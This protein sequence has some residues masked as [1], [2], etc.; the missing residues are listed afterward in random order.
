MTAG[1][2]DGLTET[3]FGVRRILRIKSQQELPLESV[4]FR[5]VDMNPSLLNHL[6]RF[7]QHGEPFRDVSSFATSLGQQGKGIGAPVGARGSPRIEPLADLC[8]PLLDAPSLNQSPAPQDR[9]S[10]QVEQEPLLGSEPLECLG[11]LQGLGHIPA[12]LMED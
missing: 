6:Q 5:L 7:R 1:D 3:S 8:N 2:R 11:Q 9:S 4:H 12:E 10:R